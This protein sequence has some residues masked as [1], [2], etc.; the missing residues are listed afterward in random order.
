MMNVLIT[1]ANGFL[2][3]ELDRIFSDDGY[4]VIKTSRAELDVSKRQ[5]VENFF[6]NN[7][8]DIVLHTAIKG[9]RRGR[10]VSF[11][12]FIKNISM[13]KNLQDQSDKFKLMFTFG[14]GAAY[15][16]ARDIDNIDEEKISERLPADYY[17]LSKNLIARE[18]INHNSNIVNLRLFGCFSAAEETNR[19]IKSALLNTVNNKPITIH[20]DKEMDFFHIRDLAT[21]IQY[22]IENYDENLP[23]DMNMCYDQKYTLKQ[24]A[25][26]IN[27]LT[28]SKIKVILENKDL[29]RPYTGNPQRLLD[30]PVS[31]NGFES[32]LKQTYKQ[33]LGNV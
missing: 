7:D 23:K 26:R 20:Q 18:V 4:S 17:G 13:Y 32:A 11:D 31:L 9:G 14:S 25:E 12:D 33:I 1:G 21:V 29:G 27:C 22:Y 30:L 2:G 19:F 28:K 15:D 8:I 6:H 24:I 16:R 10:E 3:R 5:Q